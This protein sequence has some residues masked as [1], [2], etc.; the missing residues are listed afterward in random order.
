MLL[1]V[2]GLYRGLRALRG[3]P[4]PSVAAG[5]RPSHPNSGLPWWGQLTDEDAGERR[6]YDPY[7]VFWAIEFHTRYVNVDS[8]GRR[9]TPQPPS[10]SAARRILMLGGS[11]MWGVGVR[12]SFTVPAAFARQLERSAPGRFE[13]ENWAQPSFRATQ[14]AATL[15]VELGRGPRPAAVIVLN[16]YNDA[17]LALRSNALGRANGEEVLRERLR[18]GSRG[19]WEELFELGRHSAVVQRLKAFLPDAEDGSGP[20]PPGDIC[21]ANAK[22]YERVAGSLSG[23]GAGLGFPVWF[24][25]QPMH[26]LTGKALT[27][28]EAALPT[29]GD[30]AELRRCMLAVDSV[31]SARPDLN[32]ASL[33]RI[34]DADTAS[35]FIDPHGHLTEPAST[36]VGTCIAAAVLPRLVLREPEPAPGL[37]ES[38]P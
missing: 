33:H 29:R 24:F 25:L 16:G 9:V 30:P 1:S 14:E 17:V 13:V 26:F 12:D 2:E 8:L 38:C 3:G 19:F 23:I 10:T 22:F 36:R 37:P 27:P 5:P 11:T 32:Y 15:L 21:L 28:W 4:A 6:R 34:F 7:R 20:R 31:M 18:L 35:V